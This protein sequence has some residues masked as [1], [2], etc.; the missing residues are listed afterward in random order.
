[1]QPNCPAPQL[2]P[3]RS[4]LVS[5]RP[6]ADARAELLQSLTAEIGTPGRP[7][8]A[9]FRVLSGPHRDRQVALALGFREMRC[10]AGRK[11]SSGSTWQQAV[12]SK[13]VF[14]CSVSMSM[15]PKHAFGK[16]AAAQKEAV[17]AMEKNGARRGTGAPLREMIMSWR[18]WGQL[19]TQAPT[20]ARQSRA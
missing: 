20:G 18:L 13:R 12:Q 19:G 5:P 11:K 17:D 10:R 8:P 4:S 16:A 3:A 15:H 9:G 7:R 2:P 6:R 1:M 14:S